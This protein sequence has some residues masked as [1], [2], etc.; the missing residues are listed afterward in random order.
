MPGLS[1]TSRMRLDTCHPE[2]RRLVEAVAERA[3]ILVVEGHR[4]KARQD[5]AV[6]AG[7]SK[8]PWPT[9]KHNA[10]PSRA[11]DLAPLKGGTID[12][13]DAAGFIALGRL[14]QEVAREQGIAV[15]W[16]GDWDG[17]GKTRSDGDRDERFVDLPHF[18]LRG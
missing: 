18:E 12:W 6:A 3:E 17:D 16:G 7:A 10:L 11:V 1:T 5:A 8:T 2:L 13:Q 15:R 14:V 9:S 4:S